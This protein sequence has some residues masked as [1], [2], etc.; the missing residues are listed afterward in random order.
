M[1]DDDDSQ[2]DGQPGECQRP[3]AKRFSVWAGL[4]LDQVHLRFVVGF[5]DG[6]PAATAFAWVEVGLGFA[7]DVGQPEICVCVVVKDL[8]G[9]HG[10]FPGAVGQDHT[11]PYR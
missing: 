8:G 7:V 1:A 2:D 10:W 5:F 6:Q 11:Y 9:W 4:G 3:E